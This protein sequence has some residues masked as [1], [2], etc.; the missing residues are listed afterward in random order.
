[1]SK[2][3]TLRSMELKEKIEISMN[4]GEFLK[5]VCKGGYFSYNGSLTT[6]GT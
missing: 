5:Q 2:L 6:P 4:L 1:M 3:K